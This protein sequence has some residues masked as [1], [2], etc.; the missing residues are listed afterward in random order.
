MKKV[1]ATLLC[2]SFLSPVVM[3][4]NKDKIRK[5][6]KIIIPRFVVKN[7][8]PQEAFAYLQRLTRDLDPEGEGINIIYVSFKKKTTAKNNKKVQQ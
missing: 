6:L 5:N 3:A 7:A 4:D 1:I 2:L 8:T